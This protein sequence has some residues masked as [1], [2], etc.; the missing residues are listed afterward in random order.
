MYHGVYDNQRQRRRHRRRNQKSIALLVAMVMVLGAFVG[1]TVAYLFTSADSIVNT[2]TPA[3]VTTEI[4]ENF[5][6]EVKNNVQVKN[7]GD[8]SAYIRAE[9]VVTWQNEKGEIAPTVPVRGTDYN[10]TFPNGTGWVEHE[11]FYYYTSAVAPQASTGVLLTAC[12][13]VEGKAPAGYHLS[14]EILASAIQSEPQEAV[15]E[16]WNVTIK[17]GKVE[18][19]TVN[20]GGVG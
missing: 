6:K 16:A 11:G 12:Q 5:D 14:V 13:P 8:I 18:A 15:Q 1:A 3:S 10:V 7:T 9:V 17:D 2:F 4:T 20:G 19:Y